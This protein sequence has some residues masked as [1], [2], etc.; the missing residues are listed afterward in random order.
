[1]AIAKARLLVPLQKGRAPV[2]KAA[3]VVGGGLAGMVSALDLAGQGYGVCLVERGAEL[4]GNIN[5][6]G[7]NPLPRTSWLPWRKPAAYRNLGFEP[8]IGAPD[9]LTDAL[10]AWERAHWLEAGESRLWTITWSGGTV[11]PPVPDK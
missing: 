11:P 4:G 6:G 1:M 5:H 10:G 2:T 3:L 7:W 9:T 8:A